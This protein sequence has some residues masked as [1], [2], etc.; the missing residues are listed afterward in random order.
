MLCFSGKKCKNTFFQKNLFNQ[1][2]NL[3][4]VWMWTERRTWLKNTQKIEISKEKEFL[5][6]FK[7][8]QFLKSNNRFW[9]FLRLQVETKHASVLGVDHKAITYGASSVHFPTRNFHPFCTLPVWMQ[10]FE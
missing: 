3:I 9:N 7:K 10:K 4:I 2:C 5:Q 1:T 6:I 8:S